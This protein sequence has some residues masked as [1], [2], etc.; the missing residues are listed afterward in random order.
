M[1]S[2]DKSSSKKSCGQMLLNLL[3][4]R[5]GHFLTESGRHSDVWFNSQNLFKEPNQ[6]SPIVSELGKKITR[7]TFDIVCGPMF[8]GAQI[9]KMISD[10]YDMDYV[11]SER[12][13][14]HDVSSPKPIVSYF[15]PKNSH[16]QVKGKKI[17]I[18][19]DIINAGAATKATYDVLI[20]LGAIPVL[21]GALLVKGDL[22]YPFISSNNLSLEMISKCDN[23]MWLPEEC[24]LCA[25]HQTLESVV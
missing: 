25:A 19:D 10:E 2:I 14:T 23:N 21:L 4:S 24:P 16:G 3:H 22:I 8:G 5:S 15:I 7:H 1:S 18:V 17:A 6:L 12:H 11:I 13:V 20:S 9:A